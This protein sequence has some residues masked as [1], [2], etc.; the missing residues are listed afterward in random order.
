MVYS[1]YY[2]CLATLSRRLEVKILTSLQVFRDVDRELIFFVPICVEFWLAGHIG[3]KNNSNFC[4]WVMGQT[5]AVLGASH[6][7]GNLLLLQLLKLFSNYKYTKFLVNTNSFYMNFT[8]TY[9]QKGPIPHITRTM[10]QKFL[11]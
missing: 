6:D 3:S 8:K 2:T 1:I 11:H 7:V 5:L 4:E 10:K 9:F